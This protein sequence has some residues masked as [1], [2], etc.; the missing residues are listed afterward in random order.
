MS[1]QAKQTNRSGIGASVPRLEMTRLVRGGGRYI[2]DIKRAG[3]LH[4][5]FIRSP[6][7]H[8]DIVHID[9]EAARHSPGVMAVFTG[10]DLGPI[11]EPFEAVAFNRPGHKSARQPVMPEKHV[12]WQGQ[13]VAAVVAE[14]R[15]L[16]EDAAELVEI[17]YE[18]LPVI[19]NATAAVD[20]DRPAIHDELGDNVAFDFKIH[21]GDPEKAFA[22][23]AHVVENVFHFERQTGLPLEPRGVLVEFD[24]T[25]GTLTVTQSHQSPFQMQDFYSRHLRIPEHRIRVLAPD[26][27]GAFG[28]KLNVYADEVA[29]VAI[30]IALG[31]PVKF[32]AD[33]LESFVSDIH[34]RD[35]EISARMAIGADGRITAMEVD[36]LSAVG[37]YGM[38]YRFNIAEGMMTIMNTGAPYVF[39]NYAARTRSTYVNKNMVGMYRGVGMPLA[40]VVSEVLADFA[41]DALGMD[42]IAFKRLNY[43]KRD[44]LP[45]KTASGQQ[46]DD[47]SFDAC[48]DDLVKLMNY[49]GLRKEQTAL[50]EKG[51]I[52]GI[53]ISTFVEPTAYGPPYYGPTGARI[54]VQDGCTLR[55]EP[56]GMLRCITSITDQGQGT[57]TGI[58]QIISDA[59]GFSLDHIGI[60]GGDSA[61]APYGG[62]AWASRGMAIGGEAALKAANAIK[63]NV[64]SVAASI[65]QIDPQELTIANEQIVKL[66]DGQAV[67]SVAEVAR[68]G[69]FRQDMLPADVEVQFSVTKSHVDNGRPHYMANGVQGCY[70]EVDAA[71]GFI[72]VLGQWAVDD[73]GRIINPMLV[74]EQ[75]R[76]GIVQGIGATLFEEVIYD[77]DGSIL[78]GT[79]AEYL[80]PMALDVPDILVNHIETPEAG[81]KLGAKGVGEAGLIGAMGAVWVAVN[82][83][84]KPFGAHLMH[85]PFT[86]ERV[87]DALARAKGDS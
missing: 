78:N 62:G 36:D 20:P 53:G 79:L 60:S 12:V 38:P 66:N 39:D 32:I 17:D 29:T 56:S 34:C 5:C 55:L 8:A 16:A 57:L 26:V 35:H 25:D 70:L 64:L 68:I 51:I 69:Y 15:A 28:V 42:T 3:V 44:S 33:R 77:A 41:A 58:A 86:P 11:C 10:A 13:P 48:L 31:R 83:A 52:R 1:T 24:R 81:T 87:L 4:V 80:V 61:S 65:T 22:E 23:A 82:D 73:C 72:K 9:T 47:L 7:A 43:R 84:V 71:T 49:E 14:S 75:I 2:D 21:A 19:A 18:A 40:C 45:C 27:G 30:G 67:I 74:E 6:Y 37:A 46:L 76:G 59:T 85:Q 54:S 50:R 63:R